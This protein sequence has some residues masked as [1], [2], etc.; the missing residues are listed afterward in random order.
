MTIPLLLVMFMFSAQRVE[1][2]RVAPEAIAQMMENGPIQINRAIVTGPLDLRYKKFNYD[3][4]F[5]DVQ[6]PYPVDF[7][8]STFERPITFAGS[9][10]DSSIACQGCVAPRGMSF[11]RTKM[12][13]ANLQELQVGQLRFSDALIGSFRFDNAIITGNASFADTRFTASTVFFK[14]QFLGF[15]DFT[16]CQFEGD[17]TRFESVTV[18]NNLLFNADIEASPVRFRH[19]ALF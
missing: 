15:A 4:S 1:R 9:V 5:T 19:K 2:V 6:F 7:S 17:E 8:Y 12:S 3:V 14:A 11:D 18:A 10:F 13:A 16:G